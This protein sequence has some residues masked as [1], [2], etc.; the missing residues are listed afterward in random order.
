M[1]Q[2]TCDF[3]KSIGFEDFEN[4]QDVLVQLAIGMAIGMVA[5]LVMCVGSIFD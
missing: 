3:L 2:V 4:A 1:K 5:V